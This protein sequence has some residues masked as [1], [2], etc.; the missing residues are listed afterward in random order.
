MTQNLELLELLQNPS[1]E[2][3]APE[4][5]PQPIARPLAEQQRESADLDL[6]QGIDSLESLLNIKINIHTVT[7]KLQVENKGKVAL[8]KFLLAIDSRIE[9]LISK[10]D[11]TIDM[12][13]KTLDELMT[14]LDSAPLRVTNLS[15]S[16]D[17]SRFFDICHD[18]RIIEDP[19]NRDF[20]VLSK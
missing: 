12:S 18:F 20:Y 11:S 5:L 9:D 3:Q 10:E 13:E 15:Q 8:Q 16:T 2:H 19:E 6:I 17:I 1:P 7:H 4:P 14:K